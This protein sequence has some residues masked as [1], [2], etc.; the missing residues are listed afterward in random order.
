MAT[1]LKGYRIKANDTMGFNNA[2][3]T[4]GGVDTNDVDT[5][6][7][8]KKVE[9]LYFT[10]EILDIYGE[11]GGYNLQFAFATGLLVGDSI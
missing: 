7:E 4:A 5:T 3:V 9:N 10:G 6:L 2:Q 8:S 1:L 11:C